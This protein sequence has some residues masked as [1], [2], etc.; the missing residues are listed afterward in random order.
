MRAESFDT[1]GLGPGLEHP[2]QAVVAERLAPVNT[3]PQRPGF[4]EH[5]S[6]AHA[7]VAVQ[8][9][10]RLTWFVTASG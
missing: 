7:K 5:L 3:D 9:Q 1:G 2:V 10:H 4:G 8:R 6:A